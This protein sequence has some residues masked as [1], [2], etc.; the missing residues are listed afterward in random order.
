[1]ESEDDFERQTEYFAALPLT[2]FHVFPY[3]VRSGTAAASLSDHVPPAQK[4]ERAKKLRELGARKK[5]AFARG[6]VGRRLAVLIEGK[7]K[8]GAFTG[9]SRNY[10]PV[11]VAGGAAAVNEEAEVAVVGFEN[12]ALFGTIPN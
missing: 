5:K 9:Y 10:L 3:S 7:A 2:Y 1:G 12:G 4:K 8:N 11:A 6:F